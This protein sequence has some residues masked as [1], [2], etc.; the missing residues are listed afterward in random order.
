MKGGAGAIRRPLC[1]S[2]AGWVRRAD[3]A[4]LARP[5]RLAYRLI[6]SPGNA[7][8]KVLVSPAMRAGLR[9]PAP[10]AEPGSP[11]P[12]PARASLWR[13]LRNGEVGRPGRT[14][15]AD[16]G[17]PA[18]ICCTLRPPGPRQARPSPW[19]ASPSTD[20]LHHP[21][22]LHRPQRFGP[23]G[24]ADLLQLDP[25]P[26]LA[27]SQLRPRR[28]FPTWVQVR[29]PFRGRFRP[30]AA[31]QPVATVGTSQKRNGVPLS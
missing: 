2:G 27:G 8:R 6:R 12:G 21:D 19:P 5:A 25:A 15:Q 22:L 28:A 16:A 23:S 3:A 11:S 9:R 29:F 20:L 13:R 4:R 26:I 24:P 10:P 14:Q 18:S 31:H 7:S 17:F 30:R 1:M